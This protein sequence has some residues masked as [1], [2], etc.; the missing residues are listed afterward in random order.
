MT[1]FELAL[2]SGN[3][4]H[5]PAETIL[6]LLP[7]D[8]R[9]LQGDAGRIDWYQ[10]GRITERLV[11]GYITGATGEA[12]LLDGKAPLVAGRLLLLGI[13]P[14]DLVREGSAAVM[15]AMMQGAMQRLRALHCQS[16]LLALPSGIDLERSAVDL[17]RGVIQG[18]ANDDWGLSFRLVV[19]DAPG[20]AAVLETAMAGLLNDAFAQGLDLEMG[21]V[22]GGARSSQIRS[23]RGR[24][25][26]A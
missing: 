9:P 7:E 25:E 2:Y 6:V 8:E 22:T 12:M 26:F 5:A 11:S 10:C 17:L 3:V 14:S 23:D 24:T 21:W 20:R 15:S 19:P 4:A 1:R 13:G 18:L 16:V